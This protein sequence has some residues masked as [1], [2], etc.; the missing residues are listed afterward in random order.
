M[1]PE[2]ADV[3]VTAKIELLCSKVSHCR[4]CFEID[5]IIEAQVVVGHQYDPLAGKATNEKL[6]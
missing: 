2:N 6:D 1:I 3:D 4:S 5:G